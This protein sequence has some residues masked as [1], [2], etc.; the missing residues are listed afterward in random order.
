M[1]RQEDTLLGCV[2]VVLGLLL[3]FFIPYLLGSEDH[4][5]LIWA[6]LAPGWLIFHPGFD[7]A[8]E[9]LMATLLDA[10]IFCVVSYLV[11]WLI[12]RLKRARS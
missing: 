6:L 9:I 5:K 12:V 7:D 8:G 1:Q 4:S 2:S 11:L 3:S 10:V